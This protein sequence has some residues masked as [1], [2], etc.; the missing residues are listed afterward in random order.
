MLA[1]RG[2]S[3][4][5][6][7][8]VLGYNWPDR[9]WEYPSRCQ[10]YNPCP[11]WGHRVSRES[12]QRG[13]D[14]LQKWD[15][16]CECETIESSINC[17]IRPART[18]RKWARHTSL[19]ILAARTALR[20]ALPAYPEVCDSCAQC[21]AEAAVPQ[22]RALARTEFWSCHLSPLSFCHQERDSCHEAL[23]KY[24]QLPFPARLL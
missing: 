18:S 19:D 24:S 11:Y 22:R 17:W 21:F 20:V 5:A 4:L 16:F 15:L 3:P 23:C 1:S 7:A 9:Q 8:R 10:S 12:D 13:P 14:Q 2:P 6:A